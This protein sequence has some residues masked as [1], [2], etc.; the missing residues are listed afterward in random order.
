MGEATIQ[1]LIMQ[2]LSI[3]KVFHWRNNTGGVRTNSRYLKFG[4]PGSPD[5][6]AIVAGTFLGIEVKDPKGVQSCDQKK[7]QKKTETAGGKYIVARN[8]EDVTSAVA[9]I[10]ATRCTCHSK[11]QKSTE[12]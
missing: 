6:I 8:L 4:E 7:F 2:Y 5:I 11:Q 9:S 10:L 1:T 3:A 12:E